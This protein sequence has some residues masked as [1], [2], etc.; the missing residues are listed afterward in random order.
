MSLLKCECPAHLSWKELAIVV[1]TTAMLGVT[2][3]AS[4]PERAVENHPAP[5]VATNK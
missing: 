2:L 4:A 5:H 1:I 3:L